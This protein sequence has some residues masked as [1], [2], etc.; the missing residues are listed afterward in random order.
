MNVYEVY[1]EKYPDGMFPESV[2]RR[3]LVIA[4]N[5]QE[6]KDIVEKRHGG[7][8]ECDF[9]KVQIEKISDGIPEIVSVEH[10]PSQY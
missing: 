9:D 7:D 2:V 1:S 3:V 10:F 8:F 4:N 6:A 5:K